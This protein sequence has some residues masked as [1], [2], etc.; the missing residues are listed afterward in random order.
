[1]LIEHLPDDLVLVARRA[2]VAVA[3]KHGIMFQGG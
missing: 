2:F 3:E 1:M